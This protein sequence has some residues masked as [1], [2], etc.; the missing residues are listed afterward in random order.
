MQHLARLL[1]AAGLF[2]VG[3]VLVFNLSPQGITMN[4]MLLLVGFGVL[5]FVI[6]TTLLQRG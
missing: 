6:G 4:T 3:L 5:L 2:V 1:Q